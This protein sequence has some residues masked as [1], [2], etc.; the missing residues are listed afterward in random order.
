M[1][2]TPP[3]GLSIYKKSKAQKGFTL[4]CPIRHERA[5]LVDMNGKVA[6][7]WNIG[8]GGINHA[9]L[10]P[11]GNLFVCQWADGGAPLKA[12]KAGLLRE[13]D[14]KG[15]VVWEH[16]DVNQ[17][18]D[19]RRLPNGNTIYLAWE[20]MTKKDAK[21]VKGGRPGS[22]CEDGHIYADVI[23]EVN[24]AG[25]VVWEWRTS[26]L[27]IEDY[28]IV[29]MYSRE[30]FAHA[31]TIF[32]M[33]NGDILV[34][35]RILNTIMVIDKKTRK[36]KWEMRD[37]GWGGQH[38]CKVL[39]NRNI[40]LFANGFYSPG[41]HSYSRVLEFNPRTRKVKWEY[42]APRALDF[43]SSHISGAQRLENGNTFICEGAYGRLFEVT[44]EGE[45]VWEYSNPYHTDNPEVG[46]M[47]WTFRAY[48]YTASS[49]EIQRRLSQ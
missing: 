42:K 5:Y 11:N 33:K 47:N 24:P 25:E 34:S 15:R 17:H 36:V 12:G 26:E 45:T 18:H 37:D 48:R 40:L 23:R 41:H 44:P 32:P 31:N 35:F 29:E 6:K 28:P 43:W 16:V 8:Q 27:K 4:F 49:P 39:P 19:A 14:W 20:A 1:P 46:K 22:E 3:P 9:M 38:D 2:V 13:Y 30:E 10:L 21:R 7:R